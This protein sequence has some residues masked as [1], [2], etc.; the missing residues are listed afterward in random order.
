MLVLLTAVG[1][2][3]FKILIKVYTIYIVSMGETFVV[4][5]VSK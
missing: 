3:T 4:F 5:V 1:K 2:T